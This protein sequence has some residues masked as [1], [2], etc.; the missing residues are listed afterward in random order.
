M[1]KIK[2]I[3]K[4]IGL[5]KK[6]KVNTKKDIIYHNRILKLTTVSINKIEIKVLNL[7]NVNQNIIQTTHH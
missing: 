6:E 1:Q 2:D 3:Q 4:H 7:L 5:I